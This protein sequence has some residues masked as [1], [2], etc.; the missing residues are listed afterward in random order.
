M[1]DSRKTN[2]GPGPGSGVFVPERPGAKRLGLGVDL[3]SMGTKVTLFDGA[4]VDHLLVPTGWNPREA[5]EKALRA[6]LARN[7]LESSD[8][9]PPVL[10]RYGRNSMK[11][12]GRTVTEITCHAAGASFLYP[13]VTT[14][15]DIG[16]QDSKVIALEERGT[17]RDFLMNDKCAAGTGR[18]LQVMAAHLEMELEDFGSLPVDGTPQPISS[19]CT[20]FAESEVVGLLARG[21]DVESLALGLLDA[22][23]SRACSMLQRLGGAGPVAF[24]GGVSRSSSLVRLL[25]RRLGRPVVTS[26]EGQIAGALGAARIGW[27]ERKA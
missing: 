5:G 25:E 23:A 21:V 8:V 18:F 1:M 4:L 10:T 7:G 13:G 11:E 24:T 3:G 16:G 12:R 27:E 22:V 19:M 15:L 20:V 17:V 2:Q 14:V 6:I 26:P 9:L